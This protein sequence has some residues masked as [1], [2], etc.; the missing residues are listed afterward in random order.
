M[1]FC[2]F[3][4]CL[5]Q[6][7]GVHS[8]ALTEND[9]MIIEQD[10][11]LEHQHLV[12]RYVPDFAGL[13]RS[14]IGRADDDIQTL[15]N[16]VP[17]ESKIK[18]GNAQYWTFPRSAING[19][20]SPAPTGLPVSFD[21]A[22]DEN[23][24]RRDIAH[25]LRQRQSGQMVFITLNT[26][27]QPVPKNPTTQGAPGQLELYVSTSSSN[28]KPDA[29]RND[30]AVSVD[31]GYTSVNISA[32]SD[33]YIGVSAPSDDAFSGSYDYEL[34]ASIDKPFAKYNDSSVSY[35][36]DSDNHAA[37]IWTHNT[38]NCSSNSSNIQIWM[39]QP[40][41]FNIFVQNQQDPGILGLQKSMCGLKNKAQLQGSTN[42]DMSMTLAG[43]GCPKQQFYIKG[44]NAS[45]AYYAIVGL[46][47]TDG[48]DGS[49]GP[50]KVNGGGTVWTTFNFTTKS[51]ESAFRQ[52]NFVFLIQTGPICALLYDLDFCSEV[53]YAV[54]SNLQ[55]AADQSQLA[56]FYDNYTASLIDNFTKSIAQ[57]PCDTT[58]SAQYSL[59][60]TCDDCRTAYKNWLCA[61][62]IPRCE[63][64]SN[65]GAY[66][67]PR[68]VNQSFI[69]GT[70]GNQFSNDPSLTQ[71]NQSVS[72][73]A[74]SR[75]PRIDKVVKPGPY[76]E[77]LPCQD[78]CY[79]LV[80][81]CPASLG[82]SCPLEGHG[83]SQSY[84]KP[85][86]LGPDQYECSAPF[87][88]FN[89]TAPPRLHFSLTVFALA[90]A[91]TT[92]VIS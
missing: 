79:S 25:G 66:L 88:Y 55:M 73:M 58:S 78:L 28:P 57:I 63:D 75:V 61:V 42:I 80:R 45:S 30:Q 13:D 70:Y 47:G 41:R 16:N 1:I 23:I 71:Q 35:F 50:K 40:P 74:Q 62:T 11:T 20:K 44:L 33:I 84:G 72:F 48:Q 87:A 12:N 56:G 39:S 26:C 22:P 8:K 64:F 92:A 52:P 68:A 67:Q 18:A 17:G 7:T 2:A 59:A 21:N 3:G 86:P 38:T 10:L 9:A 14:I 91:V 53:A 6:T 82:F 4:L 90:L 83:L 27:D 5:L 37:L 65:T 81:S 19:L 85:V 77:L 36:L 31:G 34:T 29:S 51:G 60:V 76:K 54:P 49:I 15:V 46:E 32:S 69:N 89:N 24:D 43:G